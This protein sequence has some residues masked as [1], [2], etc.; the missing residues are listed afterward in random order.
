M[1][2][3]RN[4]LLSLVPQLSLQLDLWKYDEGLTTLPL[5]DPMVQLAKTVDLRATESDVLLEGGELEFSL[6]SFF[7]LKVIHV[8]SHHMLCQSLHR[9]EITK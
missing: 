9:C 6:L 7:S 8:H 4:V 3:S 5:P 2:D 1:K